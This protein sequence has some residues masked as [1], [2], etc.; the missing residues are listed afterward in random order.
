MG[1]FAFDALDF[2]IVF[3]PLRVHLCA[4]EFTREAH[5]AHIQ[6]MVCIKYDNIAYMHV[7]FRGFAKESLAVRF[8]PYLH[9][10]KRALARWQGHAFQP[11]EYRE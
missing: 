9:H 3:G 5:N 11:I 4:D 8:E 6:P 2:V 7:H 10:I 1:R